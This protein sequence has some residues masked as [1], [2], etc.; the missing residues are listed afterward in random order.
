MVSKSIKVALPQED[1]VAPIVQ[2]T[3]G[4]W[5]A[6]TQSGRFAVLTNFRED[7][8]LISPKALSRGLLVRDFVVGQSS[9]C[10]YIH[11][12]K[13]AQDQYNGFNLVV[14]ELHGEAFV[15][16]NRS[17]E[18]E[19]IR[20]QDN[21]VYG[22]SNG[23]FVGSSGT[24]SWQKVS[25]GKMLSQEAIDA[26]RSRDELHTRLMALLQDRHTCSDS[27]LPPNMFNYDLEK[28]LAPI[29]IDRERSYDGDYGTTQ[30][31]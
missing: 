31:F 11:L 20:L 9:P 1:P 6:M 27:E 18:R 5:M 22:L 13:E 2:E 10:E 4:T 23:A 14:G 24:E 15:F 19:P 29:C 30:S 26:S 25:R 28:R 16:G 7:P 12:V 3:H 21:V 8:K 17:D